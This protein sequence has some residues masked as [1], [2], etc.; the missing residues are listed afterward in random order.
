MKNPQSELSMDK[1]R[2]I[3]DYVPETEAE[4]ETETE[5]ETEAEPYDEL[6]ACLTEDFPQESKEINYG[7]F[8]FRKDIIERFDNDIKTL[9]LGTTTLLNKYK[10]YNSDDLINFISQCPG[11]YTRSMETTDR[12]SSYRNIFLNK[13]KQ[14][15]ALMCADIS[16]SYGKQAITRA[17][18]GD[19]MNYDMVVLADPNI[20][21]DTRLHTVRVDDPAQGSEWFK[22]RKR[23]MTFEE[24]S[25][26]KLDSIIGFV[27][28]EKGMCKRYANAY[29]INLIC[30]RSGV[31]SGIGS[32]LMGLYLYT[33]VSHP[34]EL[35]SSAVINYQSGKA[36]INYQLIE[37]PDEISYQKPLFSTSDELIP[38]QHIGILELAGSYLNAAGLCLYEKFGFRYEPLLLKQDCFLDIENLP[39]ILSF[40][41][42]PKYKPY[43]KNNIEQIK[44][45]LIK[46]SI[47]YKNPDGTSYDVP[48]SGRSKVCGLRDR[49]AQKL[50]GYLRN[51]YI[52]EINRRQS[53]SEDP[54]EDYYKLYMR[55]KQIESENKVFMTDILSGLMNAILTDRQEISLDARDGK[56]ISI[57]LSE[58]YPLINHASGGKKMRP[59]HKTYKNKRFKKMTYRRYKKKTRKHKKTYKNK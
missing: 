21:E 3:D 1:K 46:I 30:S 36:F 31:E 52:F 37:I 18:G 33:I 32:L 22:R 5:A 44:Q 56:K 48:L 51:L 12:F 14:E 8:F 28:V 7:S 34:K 20:M 19:I 43:W 11:S 15:L 42:N 50:Y 25:K 54:D 49:N 27:I 10:L 16:E 2:K 4:T 26:Y 55:F 47:G 24:F 38:L 29:G 57:N 13:I 45:I 59:K 35:S 41:S 17:L 6:A 39:M 23:M 53:I 9:S 40:S 58:L